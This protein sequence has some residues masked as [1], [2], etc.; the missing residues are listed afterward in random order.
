MTTKQM[1]IQ[2]VRK[3]PDDASVEETMERFLFVAKIQK[4]IQQAE[5]GKTI[6]H[7]R[8]RGRMR[9]WLKR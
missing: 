4:G 5:A 6:S 1:L 2:T 3:L 9:R 8:V 7:A